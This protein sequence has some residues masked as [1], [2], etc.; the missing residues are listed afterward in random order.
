MIDTIKF[1]IP[2]PD[3]NLVEQLKSNLMRFRK[4]DLRTGKMEFEFFS[5]NIELGSYHRT[6]AIKSTNVPQGFFI[7]FSVPKYFKGNNVEMIYP[8][9]LPEILSRLYD[10]L[11]EYMNYKLADIYTWPIYRL[12]VCYNWIFKDTNEATYAMDFLRRIDFPR[13]K[14]YIYDTS[15]MYK[16]TAYTVKFYAKGSEFQAHDFDKIEINRAMALQAWADHIVRFEV[17]LKRVYLQDFLGLDKVYLKD[18]IA[19]NDITDILKYYLEKKVFFYLNA[20]SMTDEN[21]KQILFE[22]FTKTK[23]TRLYQFYKDYYFNEEMKNMFVRG[24][25]N[26]STIYRYKKDL[27]QIGIG[28]SIDKMPESKNIL[29]QLIIPSPTSRFD[30]FDSIINKV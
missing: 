11:C 3:I 5:S 10:E 15:V 12:D 22:N 18:V 17:N 23:A 19:D 26:R 8:H 24:G 14:K 6:V 28:I 20:N 25:L 29:E 7:E 16:G 30:L 13:K 4:D 2:M 1:L 9:Q 27:K 21:I